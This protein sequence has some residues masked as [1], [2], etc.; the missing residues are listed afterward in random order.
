MNTC[1]GDGQCGCECY[2]NDDQEFSNEVCKCAH[3]NHTTLN[4]GDTYCRT[5]CSYNC[6]L[7]ECHNFRLC[8]KKMPKWATWYDVQ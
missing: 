8:G 6:E 4:G 7:F 1:T 5:E 2:E 3:R